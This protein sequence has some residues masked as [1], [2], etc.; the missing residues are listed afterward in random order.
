MLIGFLLAIFSFL[1]IFL[2]IFI[3][4]YYGAAFTGWR[5]A[6]AIMLFFFGVLIFSISIIT[7]YLYRVLI[8]LRK[9]NIESIKYIKDI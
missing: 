5:S 6:I 9:P 8:I 1:S 2:L 4:Y 3:Y 7:E